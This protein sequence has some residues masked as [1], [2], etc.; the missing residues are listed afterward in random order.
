MKQMLRAEVSILLDAAKGQTPKAMPPAREPSSAV[1]RR[2]R[3][4]RIVVLTQLNSPYQVEFFNQVAAG[5]G[6]HIEVIYL[7]NKDRNR[8]WIAPE[9]AHSHVI[10]NE[11]P[12]LRKN[13]LDSIASAD[14]VVFNYYTDIFAWQAI[15]SRARSGKPWVFWGERPGFFHLGAPGRWFRKIFLAPLHERKAPIWGVGRFGIEGYQAE[16]GMDRAYA[17][18]PYFSNLD[19]F[20]CPARTRSDTCT[21]LYSGALIHRKGS[22]L[23][24]RAFLRAWRQHPRLRLALMGSGNLEPSMRKALSPCGDAVEWIGFQ[25]WDKLPL[26]YARADIFCLPSRYDG[27]GLALVE[28]LASGLPSIGTDRTG[29]AVEHI[30]EGQNGWLIPAGDEDA[31]VNALGRAAELPSDTLARMESRAREVAKRHSL[32]EGAATFLK[33]ARDAIVAG[34]SERPRDI[35]L[36]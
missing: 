24:A 11:T 17:N 3:A 28:A 18:V 13:A 16:F 29:A 26:R 10:L 20:D 30:R 5:G 25:P 23:L 12:S 6:C 4:P 2:S 19:R 7:T 8:Q 34:Q 31:L 9:I 15:R 27:W 35:R 22:D 14:L 21:V 33:S 1:L 32:R 36:L